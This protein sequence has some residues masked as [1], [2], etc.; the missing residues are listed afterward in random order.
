VSAS[1]AAAVGPQLTLVIVSWNSSGLLGDSIGA[2]RAS[3]AAANAP[4]EVVV[5]DNASEDASAAAARSSGADTV[6]ANPLNAGFVV[7]ASQG[8]ARARS[9]WVLLANPDLRVGEEFVGAVVA[10]AADA[11]PDVA[12]LVPD[13]RFASDQSIVNSRGLD[14]DELGIPAEREAGADARRPSGDGEVFGASS[15]ASVLRVDALRCV[16]GLEPA[17]FAYLEDVDVAWRLR[18]AGYRAVLVPDA[19]AVHEGSAST[20]EG[21]WLKAFLVARNRRILFRLHGPHTARVR[22]LRAVTE[23]GHATVQVLAGSGDAPLRGR[24][25]AR[26][27]RRYAEFVRRSNA[28][29]TMSHVVVPL[30]PRFTLLETLRR[31]QRASS[32]MHHEAR[33]R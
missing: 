31:K 21:S 26:R 11:P 12:S 27:T 28:R 16:G 24:I 10:A 17:Y 18:R 22:A 32:L 13:V 7:A 19:I 30:A 14:V 23:L 1:P 20:G 5:V 8:I 6:I 25:A 3:S 33:S 4:T 9:P 29:L 2:F 15:S